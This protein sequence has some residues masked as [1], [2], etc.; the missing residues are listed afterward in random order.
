MTRM[1]RRFRLGSMIGLT[2]VWM[3]LWGRFSWGAL[4]L[5]VAVSATVLAIFP[6]PRAASRIRIRPL[7][8]LQL[9]GGFLRQLVVAS[10]LVGWMAIRP[11]PL[12]PG[13][14]VAVPLHDTDDFRRTLVAELT[15]LVPGSVVMDLD[16]ERNELLVHIID[17]CDDARLAHEVALIHQRERNVARAF[18]AP[19]PHG[20]G[21][22]EDTV[23]REVT[24]G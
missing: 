9:V 13:R 4:V 1:V 5:G 19:T 3:L 2:V 11:K 21:G 23:S 18:G 10:V 24:D 17:H 8:L 22:A 12:R 16:P 6:M 15:S 7:A 14:I 20:C